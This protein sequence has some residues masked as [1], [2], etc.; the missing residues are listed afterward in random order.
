MF[1]NVRVCE[2]EGEWS[3]TLQAAENEARQAAF[4]PC[5]ATQ[6]KSVG[7]SP[8]RGIE[9]GALIESVGGQWMVLVTIE[10]RVLPASV[11]KKKLKE[12][13]TEIKVLTGR[14]VGKK[15][16][17]LIQEDIKRE[18]LPK[19]FCKQQEV[20]AWIDPGKR[21]MY[22]DAGSKSKFDDVTTLLAN[23]L[24]SFMVVSYQTAV[25]PATAMKRWLLESEAPLDFVVDDE[26]ELKTVDKA[27][28][29]VKYS[30]HNLD[31]EEIKQHLQTGKRPTKV[32][33]TWSGRVSFVLTDDMQLKKIQFLDVVFGQ[34]EVDADPFDANAA[35]MTGELSKLFEGL[36]EGLGGSMTVGTGS[37]RNN[38]VESTEQG[39]SDVGRKEKEEESAAA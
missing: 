27:R 22:V 28:S 23:S 18:L 11:V 30:R 32:A 25:S 36:V 37:I 10:Q 14:I 24:K 38:E 16:K 34:K 29:T 2:I 9:N 21:L 26:C 3:A 19:A 15:E 6:A 33:M 31:L 5:G 12:R 13:V 1:K 8:A 35:I 4:T 7:F 39:R 17:A 20:K